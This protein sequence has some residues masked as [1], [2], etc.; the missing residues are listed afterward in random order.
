MSIEGKRIAIVAS[1]EFEDIELEYPLLNWSHAGAEIVLVPVRAG[2]HPRPALPSRSAKPVTGRYGTPMPPEVIEEDTRY[3][4]AEMRELDPATLDGVFLPGGFS[5]DHLRTVPEVVDLVRETYEAG[6]IVA[7][8]CHGPQVLIEADLVEGKEVTA[9]RAVK[10]DLMNA[11]ATFR[12]VP[13]V[14]DENLVTGRV[15]DDLPPFCEE[16]V[17]AFER[18]DVDARPA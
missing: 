15:P 5:P 16:V 6:M 1:N 2:L 17:A 3:T 10:T 12:D 9:H 18:V 14:A 7:T 8:I 4:V 13:T 11:G